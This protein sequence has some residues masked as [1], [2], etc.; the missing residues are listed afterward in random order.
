MSHS[1]GFDSGDEYTEENSQSVAES[2]IRFI[3]EMAFSPKMASINESGF[4]MS[5]D[6]SGL[7]KYYLWLC[8]KYGVTPNDSV[9][10]I[11]GLNVITDKSEEW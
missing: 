5:W 7:G 11:L 3:E 9:L 6:Y 8:R 1:G 2:M 10:E 4:S